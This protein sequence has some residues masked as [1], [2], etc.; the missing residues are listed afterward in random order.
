MGFLGP[1]SDSLASLASLAAALAAALASFSA[2][3]AASL[4]AFSAEPLPGFAIRFAG[5]KAATGSA[6][7][8]PDVLDF[9]AAGPDVPTLRPLVPPRLLPLEALEGA[10][11]LPQPDQRVHR[12]RLE[13]H[14]VRAQLDHPHRRLGRELL[15]RDDERHLVEQREHRRLVEHAGAVAVVPPEDVEEL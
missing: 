4:A 7:P 2:A 3:L 14:V 11:E 9:R 13:D 1:L 15:R 8:A 5:G 12:H 10:A 6:A